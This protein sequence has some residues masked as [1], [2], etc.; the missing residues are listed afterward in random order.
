M[1]R[2]IACITLLGLAQAAHLNA[3][4]AAPPA[5]GQILGLVG[6]AEG[7][8]A[9]P[10][11]AVVFL[12]DAAT[13]RPLVA[14]NRRPLG[15]DNPVETPSALWHA[16]T[17]ADGRFMFDEVPPGEYRMFAQA[18]VGIAGLP[19][20]VRDASETIHLLGVAEGVRVAAGE[21]VRASLRPVGAGSLTVNTDPE[22]ES[23]FLLLSTAAPLGDP[24]LGPTGW[25]DAFVRGLIGVTHLTK[26]HATFLG[27]PEQG[28]LYASAFFYDNVSGVG[29]AIAPPG[30]ERTATLKIY[31]GWSNAHKD[32]PERLLP[33]VEFLEAG[34][35][36]VFELLG[37]EMDE[38]SPDAR[39]A[40]QQAAWNM[41]LASPERTVTVPG[42]GDFPA[43]DV[44]AAE[45]YKYLRKT[46]R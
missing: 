8:A 33:L 28:E 4:D 14:A 26:S 30:R 19:E 17:G 2:L 3:Q 27:V 38:S 1:K 11:R 36:T 5:A 9:A 24:V 35:T 41:V 7:Q 13:G 40:A 42:V 16:V 21:T 46:K 10:G 23:A 31:S 18:W 34:S 39:R 20:H 12:C 45:R 43:I 6:D 37:A 32:P 15:T 29:T 44:L 25:H 22:E